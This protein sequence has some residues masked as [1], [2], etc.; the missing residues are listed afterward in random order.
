MLANSTGHL[1]TRILRVGSTKFLVLKLCRLA[2]A[3]T[4]GTKVFWFFFSRKNLLAFCLLVSAC[5]DLPRPFAGNPGRAALQLSAPPPPKLVVP[6][7]QEGLLPEKDA[8]AW[9][10]QVTDALV[11]EEVPAFAEPGRPGE[12]VLRLSASVQG[13]SVVPRYE[14]IDPKGGNR[15]DV[16]GHP[17]AEAAWAQADPASLQQAASEAA[18]QVL[19]MLRSVDATIKQSDPNSLYN[20]PARIFFS[21]V[22][23]APG[24]GNNSLARGMRKKIPDTGDQL[25]DR[26]AA[27]DF[28][29]R[30][31]VKMT[32][33]PDGQQQVEIHW[34]VSDASG[35]VAGDVAQGHD[36]PKGTLDRFWGDIAGVVTDEAAGGVHEVIT[37][38]SGRKK[39]AV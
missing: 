35:K 39:K 10:H 27:A 6:A 7:P 18:P 17:V 32:D 23:G 9:A 16:T 34:L 20:R 28:L 8:A 31:T 22:T 19:A 33:E 37:N 1:S 26:A 14:L 38:F 5:G 15:G 24:D 21:G 29:L 30:G 11:A 2:A 13:Q 25:V 36:V 12:W 3:W 4:Q